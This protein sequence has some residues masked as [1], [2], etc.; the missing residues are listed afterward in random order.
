[1]TDNFHTFLSASRL[2]TTNAPLPRVFGIVLG[3]GVDLIRSC[4]FHVLAQT[5]LV[6]FANAGIA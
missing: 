6:K 5:R 4:K 1:M 2:C 3:P